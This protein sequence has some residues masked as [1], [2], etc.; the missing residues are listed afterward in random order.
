MRDDWLCPLP[1]DMPASSW[2]VVG[3]IPG[4]RADAE[5]GPWTAMLEAMDGDG[6]GV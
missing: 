2:Q 1:K 6:S 5:A 3:A 4:R